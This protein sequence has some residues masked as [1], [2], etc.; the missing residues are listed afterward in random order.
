[1]LDLCEAPELQIEDVTP[2]AG[3][4]RFL[5]ALACDDVFT[6]AIPASSDDSSLFN[7]QNSLSDPFKRTDASVS[8]SASEGQEAV[9]TC[10]PHQSDASQLSAAVAFNALPTRDQVKLEKTRE[11]NRRTQRALRQ[12]RKVQ[13]CSSS[14]IM[15][16][17]TAVRACYSGIPTHMEFPVM[18]CS[19]FQAVLEL[20]VSA[21][22]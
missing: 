15:F 3:F 21:F 18:C 14:G 19:N 7:K 16:Q 11:K 10:A 20:W 6:S 12:R 2:D 22:P 13:S 8:E 1:M 9:R 17:C 5:E 4:Q